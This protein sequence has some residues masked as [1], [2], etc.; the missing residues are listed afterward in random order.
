MT[1]WR[2]G[3]IRHDADPNDVWYGLHEIT[4]DEADRPIGYTEEPML[5]ASADEGPGAIKRELSDILLDVARFEP[6]PVGVFDRP[7]APVEED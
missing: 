4:F 7:T 3:V 2:Y 1:T 6:I 5:A